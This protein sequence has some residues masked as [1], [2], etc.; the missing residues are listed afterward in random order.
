MPGSTPWSIF[1][2]IAVTCWVAQRGQT[3]RAPSP[4][5]EK[6]GR[7]PELTAS[8]TSPARSVSRRANARTAFPA[9]EPGAPP[10]SQTSPPNATWPGW[11]PAGRIVQRLQPSS[12]SSPSGYLTAGLRGGWHVHGP[13]C[14]PLLQRCKGARGE[15]EKWTETH[16]SVMCLS[17]CVSA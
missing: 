12:P 10:P 4:A 13:A 11:R 7:A 8:R 3:V 9:Y 1:T 15:E 6:A 5:C 16:P 2:D 14:C 17:L